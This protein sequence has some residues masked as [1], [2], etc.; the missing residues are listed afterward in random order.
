[1]NP[2]PRPLALAILACVVVVVCTAPAKAHDS[3]DIK[4]AECVIQVEQQ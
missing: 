3:S 4:H 1:M 2:I